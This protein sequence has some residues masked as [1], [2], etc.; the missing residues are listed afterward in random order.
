MAEDLSEQQLLFLDLLYQDG[1]PLNL[2]DKANEIKEQA[3]YSKNTHAYKILR[4]LKEAI[5]QRNYEY[6]I[7]DSNQSINI[8]QEIVR[9]PTKPGA[10]TAIKAANSL[11]DRAGLA[12]KEMQ[13]IE[14]KGVQGIVI[15]PAKKE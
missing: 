7:L 12:K 1:L 13:E 9:T 3:G 2:M 6:M 11:L 14:I 15:L 4:P 10:D 5:S 8:L